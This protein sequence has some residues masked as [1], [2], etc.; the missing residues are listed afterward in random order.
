MGGGQG[1]GMAEGYAYR[2]REKGSDTWLQEM[3]ET[4]GDNEALTGRELSFLRRAYP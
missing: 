1:R 3:L 2:G 4:A